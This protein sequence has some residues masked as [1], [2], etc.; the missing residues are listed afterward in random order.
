ML[1]TASGKVPWL[2]PVLVLALSGCGGSNRVAV[3]GKVTLDGTPLEKGY[4]AFYPEDGQ[5]GTIGG[6]II[7]GEYTI[8]DVPLGK[9]K[10]Q[11]TLTD[12]VASPAENPGKSRQDANAERLKKMKKRDRAAR[13]APQNLMGNNRI[14]E[15]SRGMEDLNIEL[16]RPGSRR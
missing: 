12:V 11:G 2:F 14:V 10:V 3:K 9:K 5:G 15:I 6:N 4:I 1:P 8:P 7:D 13:S 16:Q